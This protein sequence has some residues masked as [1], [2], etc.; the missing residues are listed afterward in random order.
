MFTEVVVVVGIEGEH[1]D[2]RSAAFVLDAAVANR[3]PKAGRAIPFRIDAGSRTAGSA[4]TRRTGRV[5]LCLRNV[6][7]APVPAGP[8]PMTMSPGSVIGVGYPKGHRCSD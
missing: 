7:A 5:L 3:R 8:L 1:A 4:L 2:R 6:S